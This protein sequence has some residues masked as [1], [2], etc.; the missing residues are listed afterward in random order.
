MYTSACWVCLCGVTWIRR[1]GNRNLNT[2]FII[3]SEEVDCS[4][5]AWP[6]NQHLAESQEI[7]QL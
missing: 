1:N 6:L 3:G 4:H 2:Y 5:F 7:I